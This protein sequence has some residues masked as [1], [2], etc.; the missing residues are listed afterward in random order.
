MDATAKPK[1]QEAQ[2]GEPDQKYEEEEEPQITDE[3][4]ETEPY[5]S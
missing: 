5:R 1:G 2:G 4:E 3:D